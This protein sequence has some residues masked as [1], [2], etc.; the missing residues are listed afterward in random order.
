V[1]PKTITAFLASGQRDNGEKRQQIWALRSVSTFMAWL[2]CEGYR[3][4]P[5][6]V[7]PKLHRMPKAKRLPRPYSDEEL[8]TIWRILDKRGDSLSRLTV[9]IGEEAG[10]RISETCRLHLSDVDQK[11]QRL[12]VGLPN[13]TMQE[14]WVPYHEKTRRYLQQWLNDRDAACGH[15]FLFHNTLG[16]P[17]TPLVLWGHLRTILDG[18]K[19]QRRR[20]YD[21]VF[22]GFRYHRLRHTMASRLGNHGVDA[23]TL[24]AMA[25]WRSWDSMNAYVKIKPQTVETSYHE[26]MEEAKKSARESDPQVLSLEEFAEKMGTRK[27][28]P[29]S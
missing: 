8:Q 15:D 22:D 1:S 7:I 28:S 9:A 5:N 14:R 13:K 26:A 11:A 29:T 20:T 27:T 2:A 12:F 16:D 3:K 6:P 4:D 24:M 10:L 21:E 19:T 25:G 23:A 17:L 18:Y